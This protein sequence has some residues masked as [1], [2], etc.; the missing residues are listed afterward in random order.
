VQTPEGVSA[1]QVTAVDCGTSLGA[2]GIPKSF[3]LITR[4]SRSKRWSSAFYLDRVSG[5]FKEVLSQ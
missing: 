4:D 5:G 3:N 1:I 2:E